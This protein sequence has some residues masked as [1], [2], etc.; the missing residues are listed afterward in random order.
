[1]LYTMIKLKRGLPIIKSLWFFKVITDNY[2]LHFYDEPDTLKSTIIKKVIIFM[3]LNNY[4]LFYI[5][6]IYEI[7]ILKQN[8]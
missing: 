8:K 4:M 5:L 6:K 1:M 7:L 3:N 2:M